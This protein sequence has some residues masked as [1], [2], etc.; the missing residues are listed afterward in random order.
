MA[1]HQKLTVALVDK[2]AREIKRLGGDVTP[3]AIQER[4]RVKTAHK[5]GTARVCEMLRAG[6]WTHS[7]DLEQWVPPEFEPDW[8]RW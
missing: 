8:E 5:P 4:H 2:Y 3:Q 1:E 6:G 7:T